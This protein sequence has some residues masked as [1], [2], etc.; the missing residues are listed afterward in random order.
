MQAPHPRKSIARMDERKLKLVDHCRSSFIGTVII[1]TIDNRL[2]FILI[3]LCTCT[4]KIHSWRLQHTFLGNIV[5]KSIALLFSILF[6]C[7]FPTTLDMY[8]WAFAPFKFFVIFRFCAYWIIDQG[9]HQF[10]TC[11]FFFFAAKIS[12]HHATAGLRGL[13]CFR[14]FVSEGVWK[15]SIATFSSSAASCSGCNARCD[16]TLILGVVVNAEARTM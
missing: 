5:T 7:S 4:P 2:Y 6:S 8:S 11:L 3:S 10:F 1:R 13:G 12:W 9:L 15:W 16:A 14:S